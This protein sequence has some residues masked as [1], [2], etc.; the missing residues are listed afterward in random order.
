MTLAHQSRQFHAERTDREPLGHPVAR[1]STVVAFHVVTSHADAII[2]RCMQFHAERTDREPLGRPVA[3]YSAVV[4][5]HVVKSHADASIGKSAQFHAE[6]TD[7]EP[8]GCPVA[9]Y[10]AVVVF[11]YRVC[12]SN[13]YLCLNSP[14][15]R[16]MHMNSMLDFAVFVTWGRLLQ[17]GHEPIAYPTF[18][19][20]MFFLALGGAV[21]MSPC[22][23]RTSG[24]CRRGRSR[25][26]TFQSPR[27]ALKL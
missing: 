4:V 17:A 26:D 20:Y 18:S 9:R 1:Y 22:T 13:Y 24:C 2:G 11:A 16:L 21:D 12:A 6:R 8:L 14:P 10:S 3:R 7:R 23:E 15:P 19:V 5:L 25:G 27:E